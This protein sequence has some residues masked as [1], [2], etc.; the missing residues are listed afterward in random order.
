MNGGR[1]GDGGEI[2]R[3]DRRRRTGRRVEFG[4]GVLGEHLQ[5]TSAV[6]RTRDE[7][8]SPLTTHREA[9]A[10]QSVVLLRRG[11]SKAGTKKVPEELREAERSARVH[12]GG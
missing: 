12:S 8:P 2:T 3:G 5:R 7:S 9:V 1:K 11:E 4:D 10:R 6:S